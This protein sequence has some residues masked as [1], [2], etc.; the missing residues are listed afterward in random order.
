VKDKKPKKASEKFYQYESI[1]RDFYSFLKGKP[2][3]LWVFVDEK[4]RM[5]R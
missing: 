1:M 2:G 5:V 3:M 4:T